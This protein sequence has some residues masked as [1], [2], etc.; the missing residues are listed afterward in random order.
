VTH[1][2]PYDP[3]PFYRSLGVNPEGALTVRDGDQLRIISNGQTVEVLD[4]DSLDTDLFVTAIDVIN[5]QTR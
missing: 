4:I 3:A 2:H 1:S 5:A